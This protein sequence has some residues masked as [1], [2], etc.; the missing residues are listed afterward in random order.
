MSGIAAGPHALVELPA[1]WTEEEVIAE[2]TRRG[3]AVSGLASFAQ[4]AARHPPALVVG[5][6]K[7]P[8]YEFTASVAR[9][10]AVL[11]SR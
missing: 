9:L 11:S 5:Y 4:A 7:P 2:A 3:L 8:E 1:G 6:A 10:T